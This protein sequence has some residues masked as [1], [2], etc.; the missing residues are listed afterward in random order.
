MCTRMAPMPGNSER[1]AVFKRSG[2]FLFALYFCLCFLFFFSSSLGAEGPAARTPPYVE[3]EILV[4]FREG[5]LPLDRWSVHAM[6]RAARVKDFRIVEGLEVVKLPVGMRVKDAI[7]LYLQHPDV[8]YAEPNYTLEAFKEPNDPRFVDLWGLHNT[9]QAGGTIDADIDAPEAWDIT[10]GSSSVVVVVIDTGIDYNHQDLSANMFRNTSDCNSNGVDDD[11]NGFVDDCFGIDTVNSDSDPMDDNDHGT[12]VAGT[13]GAVGNNNVGVVGV[14]WNIQ[15]M[16][17]K[18]LN[19]AGSGSTSGAI[20]CLEYVKLMKDRGVNIIATSNSWGGGGF[21]Q[22][23]LDSIEAHLQRGIL[24]IAAAGNDGTD[25]DVTPFYPCN[26]YLPNIIC[27]ASTTRTDARSSFSNFGRRTV[28]IG[29]PGS[30]VWST[31][32]GNAYGQKSG[33]SMATPHVTGV[34][35]LLKAQDSSRDWKAIKNLILAGGNNISALN[36][37]ITQKRLNANG[38]L[39]CSNSTVRSRITPI[40]TTI[41]GG[42]GTPIDL[43]ALHINCASPNGNVTVTVNPGGETITLLD[44]GQVSDQTAGDGIYSGQFTPSAAGTFTLSFPD[45]DI[46]VHALRNYQ[47]ASASFNYRTIT[48]TNL[49]LGDDNSATITSP[50]EIRF[51]GGSFTTVFAS[52]NG[53]VNFTSSFTRAT[54]ESMPTSRISTLVA[55]FWDDLFPVSNSDQNVFWDVIGS[56]PNRELVVEWRNVRHFVC[57]TD[58][59]AT[60]KFQLVF[61]EGSSDVLFNYAD[62]GFGGG[63]TFADQG[64]SATVGVQVASDLGSQFSFNSKTLNNSSALLWTLVPLPGPTISVSPGSRDFGNV[65]V[66]SSEDRTFTVEN[67]GGGTL[68]G[69]ASTSAPFSILSGGSYNLAGGA[70][71]NITVRFKPSSTGTF[72]GN[73]SFTGGGGASRTVKGTGVSFTFTLTVTKAGSGDGTV[74]SSPAGVNC[75]ADCTEGYKSGTS[76]TLTAS[77]ASGSRF[78]G[79]SGG[80]CSG[81][82][83]CTVSIT[84]NTTVTATFN[85]AFTLTVTKAGSGDGTV[86]SSPS[87]INCGSTCSASFDS[88]ASVT[89]TA[90]ASSGST[91]KGWS[92]GGCS[93]T[94]T[95]SVTITANTTVTATF[96]K[97]FTDDPLSAQVTPVKAAHVTELRDAINTLRS[98]NSLS[99]FS[100]T[101]STLSVGTTQI[102][103]VHVTELRTALNGVYD[104][105]GKA[106]P[107]YTDSTITAGQTTIKKA[108]IA[109]IRQ[110]VKD[111]E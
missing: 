44:D 73:V 49:N 43:A 47:F 87:G 40:G 23:L 97:A 95:C 79:W 34:A 53:N 111:V 89:L 30:E 20:S 13:I 15:L 93:G 80:G 33:T 2:S 3:G 83:T 88:G 105:V 48:G 69:S 65:P 82:G 31:V 1:R 96:S 36:N 107:T 110:A 14:N 94:G 51:G 12:H 5:V 41:T 56:A 17:C 52:S 42:F 21:S 86:T 24:F 60:V 26:Y 85:R 18:F 11:G 81:T 100:F 67:T 39:T 27:V 19:A 29:A 72:I 101:D 38:A 58:S 106:R 8:L 64:G 50:F 92:G 68:S 16:A 103:A 37:T 77:A 66:A 61:F 22:A 25:N 6:A 76:V 90:S 104:A 57:E 7:E 62:T 91:F 71:Q 32:R 70:S 84:G 78:A 35:A 99:A 54:N 46:T 4:R 109:E 10:T 75:G 28:H 102:K 63:C 98:N 59:S 55:P 108:H 45:G 9:G 74:T